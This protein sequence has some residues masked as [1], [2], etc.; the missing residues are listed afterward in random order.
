MT[1][2]EIAQEY[3]L[4]LIYVFGSQA[5]TALAILDGQSPPVTDPL[6][7]ID[8]GVVFEKGLPPVDKRP[9]I[10]AGLYNNLQD[11]FR[12]HK[13]DLAF[14]QENHSVF[15]AS[16]FAGK[17]IYCKDAETRFRYEEDVARRAAD[18]RPILE[19]YLDEILEET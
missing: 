9:D 10:Y 15:Q 1:L 14:L 7:D 11:I 2:A 6:S 13:V 17:N 5:E 18:F 8:I 19:K 4:S 3:G 12:P 16:V